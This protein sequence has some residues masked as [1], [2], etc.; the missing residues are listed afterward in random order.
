MPNSERKF[1][2]GKKV[3]PRRKVHSVPVPGDDAN[4]V[5]LM[6]GLCVSPPE[7]RAA[8]GDDGIS[9]PG[10]WRPFPHRPTKH[11]TRRSTIFVISEP[12]PVLGGQTAFEM[13]DTE[14]FA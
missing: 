7:R 6:Y 5:R 4:K 9:V 2:E 3:A 12:N 11:K 1:R 13:S 10:T 14:N 8:A